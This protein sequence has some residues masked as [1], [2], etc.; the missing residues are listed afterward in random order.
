MN[1]RNRLTPIA[2]AGEYPVTQL[3]VYGFL[4]NAHFFYHDRRFF[5]KDRRLHA[6]PLAGIDHGA[7]G[8]CVGLCHIFNLFSVLGDNLDDR[9][10]EFCGKLKVTV[11]MGGYTHDGT[12][13]VISQYVVR[14]PDG[15]L[16]AV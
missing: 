1:D 10:I 13:S 8:L 11:I 9:N 6:V 2:L 4:A 16:C 7:A 12:C 15:N 3:I 14:Q 5:F